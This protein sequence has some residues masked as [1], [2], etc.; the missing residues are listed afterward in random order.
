MNVSDLRTILFNIPSE[1]IVSEFYYTDSIVKIKISKKMKQS[2]DDSMGTLDL[3]S[4]D[5]NFNKT[6]WK[7][8]CDVLGVASEKTDKISLKFDKDSI[9]TNI[10]GDK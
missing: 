8:I 2:A 9:K 10:T 4:E 5:L 7:Q 6:S 1:S 3:Y